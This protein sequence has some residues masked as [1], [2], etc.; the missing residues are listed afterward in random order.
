MLESGAVVHDVTETELLM[1][2]ERTVADDRD[3]DSDCSRFGSSRRGIL[4][5]WATCRLPLALLLLQTNN[6]PLRDRGLA[7]LSAVVAR[8]V[9]YGQGVDG[10]R[11][12]W[13]LEKKG[14]KIR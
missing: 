9:V 11:R 6:S 2:A 10:W 5:L 1:S 14:G 12:C 7:F 13:E 3:S 8:C 4:R